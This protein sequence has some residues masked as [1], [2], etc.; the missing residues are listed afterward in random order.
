MTV[1]SALG[2]IPRHLD[3]YASISFVDTIK[4]PKYY[5][6]GM[7]TLGFLTKLSIFE[8]AQSPLKLTCLAFR[9]PELNTDRLFHCYDNTN[10]Q[11]KRVK[12]KTLQH[13]RFHAYKI[14]SIYEQ[15][16]TNVCTFA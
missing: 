14:I 1:Y 4:G 7:T 8:L 15:A 12:D 13:L 5:G 9:G 3:W 16:K 6:F 10:V 11:L 2:F